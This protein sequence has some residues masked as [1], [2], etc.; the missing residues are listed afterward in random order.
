[1]SLRK[2]HVLDDSDPI[3]DNPTGATLTTGSIAKL[4][5]ATA[6]LMQMNAEAERG[7]AALQAKVGELRDGLAKG[8]SVPTSASTGE[9]GV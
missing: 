9:G 2:F 3:F 5:Q 8:G 7:I 4:S 1:M 6:A